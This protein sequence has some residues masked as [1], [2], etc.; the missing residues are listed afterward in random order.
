MFEQSVFREAQSPEMT[1]QSFPVSCFYMV[2][3]I[4]INGSS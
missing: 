2:D 3:K 1:S 4:D